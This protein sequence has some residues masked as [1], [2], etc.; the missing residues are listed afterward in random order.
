LLAVVSDLRLRL[1]HDLV[2]QAS[3]VDARALQRR[4]QMAIV[5]G[6]GERGP[7][8]A[9]PERA[10]ELGHGGKDVEALVGR[11][12]EEG[13]LLSLAQSPP[14]PLSHRGSEHR[15]HQVVAALA[16][17]DGD[18]VGRNPI[19]RGRERPHPGLDVPPV[20]VDEGPID[21][22]DHAVQRHDPNLAGAGWDADPG[23]G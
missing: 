21:V 19:P 4:V 10:E 20:G 11:E 23:G 9:L 6:G 18:T 13:G 16:G 17:L 14:F 12:L 2:H 22:E 8:A 3:Q 5:A 1:G 15:G 7:D